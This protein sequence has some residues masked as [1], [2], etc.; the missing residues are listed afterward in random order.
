MTF[1]FLK[2][3]MRTLMDLSMKIALP[4]TRN[5]RAKLRLIRGS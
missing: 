1:N 4:F 2:K 5:Q 3:K